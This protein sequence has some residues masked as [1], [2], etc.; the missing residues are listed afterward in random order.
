MEDSDLSNESLIDRDYV[1]GLMRMIGKM[2]QDEDK[3]IKYKITYDPVDSY[4]D[5]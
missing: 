5:F 4:L 2:N 3:S 1:G